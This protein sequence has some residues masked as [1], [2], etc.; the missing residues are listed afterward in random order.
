M[1]RGEKRAL[2]I[3]GAGHLALV[4]FLSVGILSTARK[5]PPV[6]DSIPVDIVDISAVPST[7][8]PVPRTAPQQGPDETPPETAK[9]E[10]EPT[11]PAPEPE[12]APTPEPAPKAEK[13]KPQPQKPAPE[14]PAQ[15]PA[16]KAPQK[17]RLGK[18]WLASVVGEAKDKPAT[19]QI[20]AQ[21]AAG[22][23][24]AIRQQVQPCWNPP[25]GGADVSALVTTLRLQFRKDGTVVGQPQVTEQSG[26]SASNQA[27][28]RQH[29]EA[30]KRAVL[31]CQPLQLPADLYEFWKDIEFNFDARLND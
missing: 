28:A 8:K 11:P 24:Q 31:R 22:L 18:D 10:A 3:A 30:A 20:S 23:A 27:Y 14:K 7:P 4:A 2:M 1:D 29:A 19:G 25:A 12:P 15:K 13:P 5:L 6:E 26:V 9:P 16:P 21:A 17:S